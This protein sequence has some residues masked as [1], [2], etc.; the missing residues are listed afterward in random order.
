METP[1][2]KNV[3]AINVIRDYKNFR[4]VLFQPLVLLPF[5]LFFIC[6]STLALPATRSATIWILSE[7]RP[8]EMLTFIFLLCGGFY[9]LR[10]ARQMKQQ[11]EPK[12]CVGFYALFSIG[13]ILTAMEEIA[14]GQQFWNFK[15]PA[16]LKELN[17]QGETTIHNIRGLHG[18]TEFFRLSFGLGGLIGVWLSRHPTAYK[19][20]AP[21]ILLTWFLVIAA[22][23]AIDVFNDIFPI[24]KEFDAVISKLAELVE[25]LIAIAGFLYLRIN[26][27][28]FLTQWQTRSLD[29]STA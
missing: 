6:V 20:G 17:A 15:T 7:N 28:K 19:I 8:V 11:G 1:I 23:S 29:E 9:G 5:A 4:D 12:F 27:A 16:S 22:H 14:W 3:F 18:H 10:L 21:I 2:T 13:L 26:A 25:L 24:Q